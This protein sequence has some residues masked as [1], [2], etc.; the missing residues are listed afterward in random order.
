MVTDFKIKL[1]HPDAIY[2]TYGSLESAGIDLYTAESKLIYP[3]ESEIF[4]LG[5]R[6][7]IPRGFVGLIR[8][9]SGLGFNH[10][11]IAFHGTIDS[12]YRGEWKVKLFNMHRTNRYEVKKGDRIAQVVITQ[13]ERPLIK[14]VKGLGITDRNR[15]GFGGSGR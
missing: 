8:S 3:G 1:I 14:V 2:P 11:V 7:A 4:S 9:R 15:G 12:D 13:S 6:G 5:I 10:S